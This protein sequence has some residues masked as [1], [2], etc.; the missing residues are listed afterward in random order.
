[1]KKVIIG[2]NDL[3]TT[4]HWMVRYLED[5]EDAFRYKK[6]SGKR[7]NLV[8]PDCGYKKTGT[9]N[10]L[11]RRGFSCTVCGDGISYPNKFIR[12]L[13]TNVAVDEVEFEYS[14]E[15]IA[16]RRY[17]AYFR[18]G[19]MR[20]VVEMDGGL[21]YKDTFFGG[22]KTTREEHNRNDLDKELIAKFHGIEVIRIDCR[23]NGKIKENI[24][25]SSMNELFNLSGFDFSGF[26]LMCQKSLVIQVCNDWNKGSTVADLIAKYMVCKKTILSW[27]NKGTKLG[28]CDYSV[29]E[30]RRRGRKRALL[31]YKDREEYKESIRRR[32]REEE[33]KNKRKL[34]R[35]VYV[36]SIDDRIVMECDSLGDCARRMSE[37]LGI[38]CSKQNI[39][40]GI[41]NQSVRYG[42]KY[43]KG[44]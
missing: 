11:F 10:N 22:K 38:E 43:K 36:Y 18:I 12:R 32:K 31:S 44:A 42:F 39:R 37:M 41:V 28:I 19:E 35:K 3:N 9:L 25:N 27:L 5:K 6:S 14:P 23:N 29:D 33:E 24:L 15:W 21:H 13:L 4:A 34:D 1:M 17:D 40:A 2:E 16:P 26:D 20:Y 8:C 7:V 30:S